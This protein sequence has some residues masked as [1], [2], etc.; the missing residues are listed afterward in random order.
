MY[1]MLKKQTSYSDTWYQ[2]NKNRSHASGTIVAPLVIDALS[3]RPIRSVVDVGCGMGVW[4]AA[5]AE[6]GATEV[7][8]IDGAWVNT[9]HLA[10]PADRFI[11]ADLTRPITLQQKFDLALCMEVGEHLPHEAAPTLVQSLTALAPVVLFSAAIPHQGG[12]HHINEQ[13]PQYWAGHFAREG[14]T[15]V[16]C[17]R[18]KIW[19]DERLDYYYAQNAFLYVRKDLLGSYPNLQ[20]EIESGNGTALPLVHPVKFLSFFEPKPPFMQ[21][22]YWK[23]RMLVKTYLLR[24]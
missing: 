17:I 21:R 19:T 3:P 24:R 9:A 14:Y 20:K 11:T 23:L 7:T 22:V 2:K 6:H 12:N 18:R 4:A 5:F 13:W 10:I 1:E 16:D 15:P 8:G